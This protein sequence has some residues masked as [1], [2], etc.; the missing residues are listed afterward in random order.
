[1]ET[2]QKEKT[3]ADKVFSI[4][5]LIIAVTVIILAILQFAGWDTAMYI[6]EPLLGLLLLIQSIQEWKKNRAAAIINLCAAVFV[7]VCVF[8]IMFF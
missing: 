5:R 7:F 1:M 4:A 3:T 2:N 8:V 6:A